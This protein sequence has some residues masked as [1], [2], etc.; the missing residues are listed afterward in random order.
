MLSESP[1]Q[2]TPP[3]P[4]LGTTTPIRS[5]APSP[6]PP[7]PV[8]TTKAA[9]QEETSNPPAKEAKNP[10]EI[11][12]KQ[13]NEYV[14]EEMKVWKDEV[15]KL[16]IFAGLFSG[17]V[18]SFAI[19]AY[20]NVKDDPAKNTNLLLVELLRLQSNATHPLPDYTGPNFDPHAP[21]SAT[22]KRVI[23]Y[24]FLSLI[25]SLSTAMAGILCLQWIREYGRSMSGMPGPRREH[26]GVHFMRYRGLE[27][28]HVFTILTTLPLLL[29]LS[30]LL[31]FVGIL[32]LLFNVDKTAATATAVMAGIMFLFILITTILPGLVPCGKSSQCPYKSPQAWIFY[33]FVK[34]VSELA[35]TLFHRISS[36]VSRKLK[37][38]VA[39]E[40][41]KFYIRFWGWSDYDWRVYDDLQG[42]NAA[43][44]SDPNTTTTV[45]SQEKQSAEVQ[46]SPPT[47]EKSVQV[48]E[49][50]SLFPTK[51]NK[52]GANPWET[53]LEYANRYTEGE[54]NV[55]KD[56]VDK[57]LIFAGLFSGV[58]AS[59][60]VEAYHNVK[61]DPTDT[62]ALLLRELLTLQL[63]ATN[64]LP[65]FPGVELDPRAPVSASARR[66]IIYH[67]LSLFL[68]LSTAMAGIIVS[69]LMSYC[70]QEHSK[71]RFQVRTWSEFDSRVYAD[72]EQ[73]STESVAD[74]LHK[75][76][77]IYLHIETF[78]DAFY[79]CI[80]DDEHHTSLHG[81]LSRENPP[82]AQFF[83]DLG[84]DDKT[85]RYPVI[86]GQVGD[87]EMMESQIKAYKH[88]ILVYQ[89][90]E[91]L[92]G[93]FEQDRPSRLLLN[94]RLD[95]F[96]RLNREL[97]LDRA[98][99]C[100]RVNEGHLRDQVPCETRK[101]LL[102]CILE[103]VEK[104]KDYNDTH[105]LA[106]KSI[107]RLESQEREPDMEAFSRTIKTLNDW[108]G[109]REQDRNGAKESALED[110]VRRLRNHIDVLRR[111]RRM[112]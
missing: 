102:N 14:E 8:P 47:S 18:A 25:L 63:N 32:E 101:Q 35:K 9:V 46:A 87:P 83:D 15:E 11:C 16:L 85:L 64:P 31:F 21:A 51:T 75:L 43:S 24:H 74:C 69:S 112:R 27:K 45:Q 58:V 108:L 5:G 1:A 38:K 40:D 80:R 72:L 96:L 66:V 13:A 92:V 76:G 6:E 89:T 12:L 104:D 109:R 26:L 10:W 65:G 37:D 30:L 105:L 19:E 67:F 97:D 42:R 107:M 79:Q 88:E 111:L 28:W 93:S 82:R 100:P 94:Q 61:E 53:C 44:E 60:A 110:R 59:F 62:T 54:I 98:I 56:E 106:V 91:Y 41:R 84:L 57:L 103:M 55:W 48:V 22:A 52:E 2:Q 71:P 4:S 29:L 36:I 20:H 49:T 78:A 81:I 39:V 90:L 33:Q 3:A 77:K 73:R 70:G 7:S 23:I 86:D 95:V 17:V 99:D 50:P 68:S 34:T